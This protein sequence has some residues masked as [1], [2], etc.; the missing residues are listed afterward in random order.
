MTAATGTTLSFW[1]KPLRLGGANYLQVHAY[2]ELAGRMLAAICERRGTVRTSW[3]DLFTSQVCSPHRGLL[4]RL[5]FPGSR[6]VA[7]LSPLT[8]R[9][10]CSSGEH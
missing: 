2:R 6:W 5:I 3:A 7:W 10:F 4:G 1:T 9:L 8:D